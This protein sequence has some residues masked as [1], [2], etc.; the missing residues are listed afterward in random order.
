M[1]ALW[2]SETIAKATGGKAHGYFWASGVAYDSREVGPGDLFIALKGTQSDGHDFVDKAREAGAAGVIVDRPMKG[3]HVR[4]A[5]T[6][7][8][9]VALGHAARQRTGAKIIGVTGS[10]GKTGT[11]EALF[12]ALD[13]Q[14]PGRAHRS[15]KSYNNHVGVPLS[16]ARMPESSRYGIFEMGMNHAGE[17]AALT[18]LVRPH[19]AIVTAIAPA[20]I[21]YFGS[22]A[23]IADAKGEIFEG[24]EPGGT[25]IIPADSPHAARLY[26]KAQ[27]HAGKIITFGFSQDADVHVLDQVPATSGGTMLTAQLSGGTISFTVAAPGRHWVSNALA[28]MAAVEAV[29]GDLAIAGLALADMPGLP[30]RGARHRIDIGD[31]QLLLIDESYNANPASM[32]ATLAQ[33]AEEEGVR[34]IAVLG[35]MK[36]LGEQSDALHAALA[37]PVKAAQ[38]AQA[39]LVGPEMAPL[40]RALEGSVPLRHVADAQAAIDTLLPLLRADDAVLVK[41]S[42]SIGLSRLVAAIAGGER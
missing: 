38:L 5:D 13:R 20:H 3:P 4:V 35:A 28:I 29:G 33:L 26:A 19:V 40:A 34:R 11:K 39:V 31:G 27:R 2:T 17:L 10:V 14:S 22:E 41:G 37:G 16:L 32:E 12:Q 25:A 7:D 21:G 24:L 1:T 23:A 9:L 15:V 6:T 18:Q 8:A 42:N 30:G 36:E